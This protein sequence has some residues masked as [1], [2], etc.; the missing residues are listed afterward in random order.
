VNS[1]T[2]DY[3]T[4]AVKIEIVRLFARC[5]CASLGGYFFDLHANH[6][7]LDELQVLGFVSPDRRD[8][9]DQQLHAAKFFDHIGNLCIGAENDGGAIVDRVVKVRSC[10]NDSVEVSYFNRQR[11]AAAY[12]PS[13]SGSG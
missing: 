13:H 7:C 11:P 12:S 10:G 6:R 1:S 8:V 2:R 3:T 9:L 5:A 4:P